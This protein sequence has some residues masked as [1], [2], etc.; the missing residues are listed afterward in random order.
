MTSWYIMDKVGW[1]N[2]NGRNSFKIIA[3][4]LCFTFFIIIRGK[5]IFIYNFIF[6][7]CS[8]G[9]LCINNQLPNSP[10]YDFTNFHFCF[11]SWIRKYFQANQST[12][13]L[14]IMFITCQQLILNLRIL[15]LCHEDEVVYWQTK[16]TKK[17][18]K[19]QTSTKFVVLWLV[20]D[21]WWTK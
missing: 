4:I 17:R 5:L 12:C 20:I 10:F 16:Q 7:R 19:H 14:F 8:R 18:I 11:D 6:L 13:F 2:Q 21:V 15:N 1:I 9:K 3:A